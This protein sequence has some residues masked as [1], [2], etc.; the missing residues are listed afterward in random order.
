MKALKA[1]ILF[2]FAGSVYHLLRDVLQIADIESAFTQIAH[3]DH[4]WCKPICDYISLPVD[5]LLVGISIY[6]LT[7][8]QISMSIPICIAVLLV[9]AFCMALAP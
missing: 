7:R 6:A 4:S 8:K 2:V 5:I 1:L 9:I 3:W